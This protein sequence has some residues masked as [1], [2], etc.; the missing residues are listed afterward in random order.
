MDWLYVLLFGWLHINQHNHQ[1]VAQIKEIT[2]KE[3]EEKK[4]VNNLS[5]NDSDLF[6]TELVINSATEKKQ[7]VVRLNDIPVTSK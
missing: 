6:Y 7:C 2:I 1:K 3:R 4:L 5:I